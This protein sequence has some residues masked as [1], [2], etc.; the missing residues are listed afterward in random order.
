MTNQFKIFLENIKNKENKELLETI[1]KAFDLIFESLSTDDA[2]PKQSPTGDVFQSIGPSP[3][4]PGKPQ[5]SYLSGDPRLDIPHEEYFDN[6]LDKE[7][8]LQVDR[9][10]Q[11]GK[12]M[13]IYPS[14]GRTISTNDFITNQFN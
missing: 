5:K 14:T 7:K 2:N 13:S 8:L 12:Q 1:N 4:I 10:K 6:T 11:G 9:A 3:T